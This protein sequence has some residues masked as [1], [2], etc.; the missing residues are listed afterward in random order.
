MSK[1]KSYLVLWNGYTGIILELSNQDANK[2]FSALDSMALNLNC[3]V[4]YT[5]ENAENRLDSWSE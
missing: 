1:I 3:A 4:E 2:V 5:K